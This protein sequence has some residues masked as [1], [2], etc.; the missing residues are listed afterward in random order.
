MT[1]LVPT[2]QN[3]EKYILHNETLKLYLRLGMRLTK[4][5]KV[6]K[7]QQSQWLKIYIDFNARKRSQAKNDFEKDF[8]KLMC[9]R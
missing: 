9:N 7:F 8:Y 5:H 1:K 2:L 3:K 6:I 4:I